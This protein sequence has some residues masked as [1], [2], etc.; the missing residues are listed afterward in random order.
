MGRNRR[1]APR[2][3][4]ED[5]IYSTSPI[6]SELDNDSNDQLAGINFSYDLDSPAL[7]TRELH[8]TRL[9]VEEEAP[10]GMSSDSPDLEDRAPLV[11]ISPAAPPSALQQRME[12]EG[13]QERSVSHIRS[14]V[15]A[16]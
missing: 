10:R 6:L 16:R 4:Q 9:L 15:L 11:S 1:N 5:D 13:S 7:V 14:P 3:Q 12:A 2:T 8:H